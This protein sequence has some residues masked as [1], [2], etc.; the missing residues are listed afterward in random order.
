M[1]R[2]YVFMKKVNF[3]ILIMAWAITFLICSLFVV[4]YIKHV[5]TLVETVSFTTL[6]LGSTIIS[7]LLYRK[8]QAHKLI[9]VATFTGFFITYAWVLITTKVIVSFAFIFPFIAMFCLYADV[10]LILMVSGSSFL[11]NAIKVGMMIASG[12]L[13][14]IETLNYEVQMV[15]VILFTIA[16]IL[17][18]KVL[19]G[20]KKDADDNLKEAE[21]AKDAQSKMVDD[22]LKIA[23]VLDVNSQQVYAIVEKIE[24]SSKAVAGAVN[25]IALGTSSSSESIQQQTISASEIQNK[26]SNTSEISKEMDQA[27]RV[28]EDVVKR[29]MSIVK[30]L[31]DKSKTVN[32]N[33]NN[34]YEIMCG[35]Q[36]KSKDIAKIT[37]L[38]MSIAEQTNLLALNATIEAARVGDAGK[39]FAV[40]ASEVNKLAAQSKVSANN[41]SQIIN[42][43]QEETE[44]SVQAVN[45]LREFNKEQSSLVVDTEKML[46]EISENTTLV[47]SKISLVNE[48]IKEIL[49]ANTKI[50]DAIS[51]VSAVSEQ[52][53]T[54]AEEANAITQEH[55]EYANEAK[56]LV[57]EL[58]DTSNDMRK[59]I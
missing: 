27:S 1:D 48:R 18:T 9:K 16:I 23:K 56:K 20:V 10:K 45:N 46:S 4:D 59:Y 38:I 15:M 22:I 55:I 39:G 37:E 21:K 8:N 54:N 11:V 19:A 26:L 13:S 57:I 43:L 49:N 51:N 42:Q 52:T 31:S 36:E 17:T 24:Q 41:I 33:N 2:E 40:V 34:V 47:R 3:G 30:N 50:V 58:V 7:T 12:K 53:T 29:G 5:R 6:V 44:K 25:E 14:T 35:L 28:T 32:D